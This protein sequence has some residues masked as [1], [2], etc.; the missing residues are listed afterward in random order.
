V[1]EKG[2]EVIVVLA[3]AALTLP[4]EITFLSFRISTGLGARGAL[5]AT[6]PGM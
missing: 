1:C 2:L 5:V 6:A 3:L 4:L